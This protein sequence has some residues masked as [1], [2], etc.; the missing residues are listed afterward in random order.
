MWNKKEQEAVEFSF[1][2]HEKQKRKGTGISYVSHP[3]TVA[4]ILAKLNANQTQI[5]A[6]ILHDILEDTEFKKT[7]IKRKFGTEVANLVEEV[8]ESDKD[9]P[10]MER[11][12]RAAAKLFVISEEAVLV[13]AADVLSNMV[14]LITDLQRKS[15]EAFEIFNT[16]KNGKIK[17]MERVVKILV[18]RIKNKKLA[19]SLKKNLKKIKEYED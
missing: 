19:E 1:K 16:D 11:K 5:L 13:K 3:M 12:E 10:Y 17:Q 4:V 7:D 6:G 14:D 18:S 2:A 8:S 15:G 9:M